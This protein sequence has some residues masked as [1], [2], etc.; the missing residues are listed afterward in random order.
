[1]YYSGSDRTSH[2]QYAYIIFFVLYFIFIPFCLFILLFSPQFPTGIF[3]VF[4]QAGSQMLFFPVFSEVTIFRD[5][6][7][8]KINTRFERNF[9]INLKNFQNEN[10][11][12]YYIFPLNLLTMFSLYPCLM[13]PQFP[14]FCCFLFLCFLYY[15]LF[16]CVV[17]W[18]SKCKLNF[19]VAIKCF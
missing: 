8:L 2:T 3:V 1:M 12:W 10:L 11:I 4:P 18:K 7:N 5:L 14:H 19:E 16:L 15:I 17:V 9:L 6:D 13:C